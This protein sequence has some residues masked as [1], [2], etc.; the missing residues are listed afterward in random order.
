LRL[1]EIQGSGQD[2]VRG[3]FGVGKLMDSLRPGD[4]VRA[5]VTDIENG[6]VKMK[7]DSGLMLNAKLDATTYLLPGDQ[8]ELESRGKDSSM[9][10][11]SVSREEIDIHVSSGRGSYQDAPV[12]DALEVFLN[13]LTALNMPATREAARLMQELMV[14][15]PGLTLE[16]AAFLASNKLTGNENMMKAALAL[17]SGA[18]KT[19]VMI[20]RLLSLLNLTDGSQQGGDFALR[21][22]TGQGLSNIPGYAGSDAT[23]TLQG[24]IATP[25]GESMQS[26]NAAGANFGTQLTVSSSNTAPLTDL[27]TMFL[28]K[29][30][31]PAQVLSE[32]PLGLPTII[33]QNDDVLQSPA[34]K[35]VQGSIRDGIYS[36]AAKTEN[37]NA[38][39]KSTLTASQITGQAQQAEP[40]YT[41]K[42]GQEMSLQN[43]G[44]SGAEPGRGDT[45]TLQSPLS[46]LA[47]DFS[48][49]L[50]EIPEF[51][52]TPAEA[53]ERFS[54]MLLKIAGENA[55]AEGSQTEKLESLLD[56]L[57]TRVADSG[58]GAKLQG[59]REELF[60]RLSLIEEAIARAAPAARA[61][62]LDN[63]NK[64]MEHVKVLNS[65]ET[66][67]YMQLPVKLGDERKSA[68]LYIFKRKGGRKPDPENVNILLSL[69]LENMGHWESLINIKNK[70]VSL[71]MEVGGEMEMQHF[72]DNTV[73]LHDMLGQV[74]F[75]LVSTDIAYS[76]DE[77]TPLTALSTLG[78]F[79]S[80]K[81][82]IIDYRI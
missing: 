19:D 16:E 64:L 8:V 5:V 10:L 23:M 67:A 30:H 22:N 52:G 65:I 27:L 54:E 44:A 21:G 40:L 66:F 51:R 25:S 57:F 9:V 37:A 38:A 63:V 72:S 61:E 6:V 3:N 68:D 26:G 48:A 28:S 2:G 45:N 20:A 79:I 11:H 13:K 12:R 75:R 50:S 69:E 41:S 81:P 58:A 60:A 76:Q 53:L 4:I 74:G 29:S 34:E 71:R 82:G 49:L 18:E 31:V 47:H 24:Q 32:S 70:D 46:A 36:D 42:S 73:L 35:N 33:S 39:A 62:M 14:Q 80:G 78:R 15:N 17:L 43:M 77:T 7:T 56:K 59:A 1:I 55:S